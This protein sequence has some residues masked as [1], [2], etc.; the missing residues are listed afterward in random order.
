MSAVVTAT[1]N[2]HDDSRPYLDDDLTQERI[3]DIDLSPLVVLPSGVELNEWLATHSKYYVYIYIYDVY[4]F[5]S[6]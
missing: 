6:N 3:L 4:R 5:F 2:I 1:G